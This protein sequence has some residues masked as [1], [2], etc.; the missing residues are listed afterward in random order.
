MLKGLGSV[1]EGLVLAIVADCDLS[2]EEVFTQ[3]LIYVPESLK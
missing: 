2:S 1:A 3:D